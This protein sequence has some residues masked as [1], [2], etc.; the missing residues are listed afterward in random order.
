VT[1]ASQVS[2]AGATI[3]AAMPT[4]PAAAPKSREEMGEEDQEVFKSINETSVQKAAKK[5][6]LNEE[7][8]E[9]EDLKK[10]LERKSGEFMGNSQRETFYITTNF[11]DEYL[12]TTLKTMFEKPDGQ[13]A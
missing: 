9:A 1:A 3:S 10:R 2:A 7:A 5:R 12:L 8:Q 6:K 13:D 11:S 4:I